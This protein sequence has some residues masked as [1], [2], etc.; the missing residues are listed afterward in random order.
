MSRRQWW[1]AAQVAFFA[2]AVWYFTAQVV[3]Q[4]RDL[5]ALPAAL[6]PNWWLLAVSALWVLASYAVLIETWRQTVIAWGARLPWR[7]AARIWFVSN[8]GRYVPGKIWQIG[9]M[10]ALAQ[11]AGVSSVAAVG[12]SLVVN[13]A[14]LLAAGLVVG[15]AGSRRLAGPGFAVGVVVFLAAVAATPWLLP[16]LARLAQRL[17]GREIPEPRIPPL[18]IVYAV[19]GCAL[20]WSLYGIAFRELAIALF[21][22]AAGRTSSYT[23]VFTLSYLSGYLALF[24]PGGLGVREGVLAKLLPLA[25]LASGAGAVILVVVSRLWLTVLEAAPGLILLALGRARGADHR[26]QKHGS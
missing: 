5:L 8:L 26:N 7:A 16:P 2:A 11:R 14:N 19:A 23:A 12:S 21:G 6:H 4:W 9:A 22:E 3:G 24:A 18:A 10:G 1:L 25:G 13:L 20:A 17:T 15:L